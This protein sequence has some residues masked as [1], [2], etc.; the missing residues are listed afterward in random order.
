MAVS[1]HSAAL[2]AYAP[3]ARFAT[4]DSLTFRAH[5]AGNSAPIAQ[6]LCSSNKRNGLGGLR[7]HATNGH[8]GHVAAAAAKSPKSYSNPI[9]LHALVWVGGW[10][11][12]ECEKAIGESARL[13]YDLIE[14]TAR[15]IFQYNGI[16]I[17]TC[18]KKNSLTQRGFWSCIR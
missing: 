16:V 12:E 14:G 18:C 13:G 8:R 3:A 4:A 7:V 9:G 10:S 2:P 11:N 5:A 1:S 15:E 17:S 6:D